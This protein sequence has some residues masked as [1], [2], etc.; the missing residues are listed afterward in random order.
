MTPFPLLPT[1]KVRT[2]R[3]ARKQDLEAGRSVGT[4]SGFGRSREP[5]VLGWQEELV[6]YLTTFD[7]LRVETLS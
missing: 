6:P 3:C 7:E 5:G 2:A 4:R 1:A